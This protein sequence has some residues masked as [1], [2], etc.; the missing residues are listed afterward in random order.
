M[1]SNIICLLRPPSMISFTLVH[2]LSFCSPSYVATP[3]ET[4]KCVVG[5]FMI[6]FP[7]CIDFHTTPLGYG[8]FQKRILY[9]EKATV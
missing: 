8:S 4:L 2:F 6:A 1:P 5:M 3:W 7:Y 9:Q